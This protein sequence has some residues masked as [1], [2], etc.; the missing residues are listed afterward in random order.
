MPSGPQ[1]SAMGNGASS[2]MVTVVLKLA[3]HRESGPSGVVDQSKARMRSPISP[4]EGVRMRSGAREGTEEGGMN[5]RTKRASPHLTQI[6][7]PGTVTAGT[8]A[9]QAG[10]HYPREATT[11][12]DSL[13]SSTRSSDGRQA[14]S[15]DDVVATTT[16]P[17]PPAP[18]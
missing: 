3:G 1:S 13:V 7:S 5:A 11:R 14:M 10:S 8:D 15:S 12:P 6:P 4:P 18:P 2:R 9:T 17:S 16:R